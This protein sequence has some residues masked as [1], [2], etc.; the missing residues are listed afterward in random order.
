MGRI[1]HDL[2]LHKTQN[3]TSVMSFTIAVDRDF[4]KC[5]E[6]Q[7]DFVTVVV[8]AATAEF[9]AKYFEKGRMIIADG[10]LQSRGYEDRN[11]IK[12]TAWEVNASRIYFEK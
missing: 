2:E 5:D 8:W 10:A 4:S 11:G 3:G 1:T 7:T 9:V 12:R 6:K